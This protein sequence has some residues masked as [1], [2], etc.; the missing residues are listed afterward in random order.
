MY[1][2]LECFFKEADG[3]FL[4]A[5]H[6]L[7]YFTGFCGGEGI[8]L[9]LPEKRYLFVDSRYT[10]AAQAEAPDFEVIEFGGSNRNLKIGE[11]LE[12][13]RSLVFEEQFLSVLEFRNLESAFEKIEWKCGSAKLETLRMIKNEEELNWLRKA[14]QI[15]VEAYEAVIP[16]I[17]PGISE[18]EIAAE[19]EYQMRKRGAEGTSFETIAV[20]GYKTSM[21]HG[22]PDG[23]KV[24]LGEL[25]TM[26]FGCRLGGYCSDMTRTVSVG[27]ADAEQKRIYE[28]VLAAQ[29]KGLET[30]RAGIMGKE[31]DAAARKVIADAGYGKYFGHSLGHGVGLL[32]HELPNLSPASEIR[33]EPGM[34]VTC[35]PGIYIPE[36][37]GVRIEDMVH[38][39]RDGIENLT[40]LSKE[41]IE[42]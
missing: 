23:K 41:L 34:V 27:K 36:L 12:G 10:V 13:V 29:K 16:Q 28:T 1:R 38:V 21:P 7:R 9:V 8:A 4:N 35:E 31:A 40:H 33:L 25:V 2:K 30:I 6:S 5:P 37:G 18:N 3:V 11:R 17:R 15:G 26:D 20:S 24:A 14:E 22:K 32:I 19:L 42:L 39:T